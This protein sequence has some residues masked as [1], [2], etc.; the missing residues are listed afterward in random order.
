MALLI[1]L[2]WSVAPS[3]LWART[4]LP[5]KG[6]VEVLFTPWDDAEGALIKVLQQA[7]LQ[8]R[9]QAYIFTSRTLAKALIEAHQRGVDVQVLADREMLQKGERS[10]I[11]RLAEAGIPVWLETRYTVAHNKI[12]LIDAL[13]AANVVVTGSYNYTFSAQARNAENLLILRDNA[14][15]ARVYLDHWQR[16]RDDAVVYAAPSSSPPSSSI[17]WGAPAGKEHFREQ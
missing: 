1:V 7:R 14:A 8:I 10:Q 9:V 3:C 6:S 16:H 17:S 12:M 5:A 2:V 15:L 13:D 11:P 4:V